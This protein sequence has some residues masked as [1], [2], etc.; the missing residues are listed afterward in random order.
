MTEARPEAVLPGQRMTEAM[1][2]PMP[3]NRGDEDQPP[4]RSDDEPG[5]NT[6]PSALSA[7]GL[8]DSPSE[9]AGSGRPPEPAGSLRAALE[10]VLLV[11]DEPVSEVALA[12]VVEEPR[13]R[14]AAALRA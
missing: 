3:A 8:P 1:S 2:T 12:Q 10:A 11:V 14:V 7:P 9:G 5:G 6:T 13:D 4:G